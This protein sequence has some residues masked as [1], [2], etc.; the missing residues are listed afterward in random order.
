[1]LASCS[2]VCSELFFVLLIKFSNLAVSIFETAL[3]P[4]RSDGKPEAATAVVVAPDDVHEVARNILR[5]I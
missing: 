2:T 1:V 3:L 5:C 4:L